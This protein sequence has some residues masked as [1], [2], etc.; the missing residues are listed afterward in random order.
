[1]AVNVTNE[2]QIRVSYSNREFIALNILHMPN[3]IPYKRLK[4]IIINFLY[5]E[6]NDLFIIY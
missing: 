5:K 1:M 3:I 6:T 4:P 2:I